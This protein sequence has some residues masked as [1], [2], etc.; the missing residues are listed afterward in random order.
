MKL[1]AALLLCCVFAHGDDLIVAAASDLAPLAPKLQQACKEK[2][3]FTF[4][5]SG[6][7]QQQIENGA[8]FDVF[9]SASEKSP[10]LFRLREALAKS[11]KKTVAR[12][13]L[14]P[15][16]FSPRSPKIRFAS[17]GSATR[18]S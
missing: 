16:P 7:L 3:R 15:R 12:Y 6:S 17:P 4:A 13:G 5:S 2:I 8:P 11:T 9:L 18:H 1:S 10:K 14:K